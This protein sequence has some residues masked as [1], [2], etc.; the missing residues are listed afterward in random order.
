MSDILDVKPTEKT[1]EWLETV[2]QIAGLNFRCP[3]CKTPLAIAVCE[4]LFAGKKK[5]E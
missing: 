4:I 2:N 3:C 1:K 5:V